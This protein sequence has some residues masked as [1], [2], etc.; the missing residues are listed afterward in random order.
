MLSFNCLNFQRKR[1]AQS[2]HLDKGF[3]LYE[4]SVSNSLDQSLIGSCSKWAVPLRHTAVYWYL[5]FESADG[6]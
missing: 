1:E 4:V 5:H 6:V 2:W 3:D